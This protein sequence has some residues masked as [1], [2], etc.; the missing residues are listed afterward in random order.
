MVVSKTKYGN[1]I[2]YTGTLGEVAQAL[3]DDGVPPH[4]F[5]IFYNGTNISAIIKLF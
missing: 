3:S 4:K 1:C 2:T 5:T